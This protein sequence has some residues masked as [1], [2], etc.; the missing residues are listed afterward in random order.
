MLDDV[1]R[2][3][4][5]K[6]LLENELYIEAFDIVKSGLVK[7]MESSALGDEITHNRLVIALQL[8]NQLNK[9]LEDVMITGQFKE[10]ETK[11]KRRGFKVF[12]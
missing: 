11:D 12:G 8:L 4:N 9:A 10:I 3:E 5:A 1:T 2:G 7:S 6:Q